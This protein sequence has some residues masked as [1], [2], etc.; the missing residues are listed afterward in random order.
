M[1]LINLIDKSHI[2]YLEELYSWY[3]DTFE[4]LYNSLD[5]ITICP[6]KEDYTININA[7]V[8]QRLKEKWILLMAYNNMEEIVKLIK[9]LE[10]KIYINTFREQEILNKNLLKKAVWQKTTDEPEI[11]LDKFLQK[12]IIWKQFPE[13]VANHILLEEN[14]SILRKDFSRLEFPLIIKPVWWTASFGVKKVHDMKELVASIKDINESMNKLWEYW[15]HKKNIVIE[16]FIEWQLYAITYFVDEEQN[17]HL[18]RPILQWD[19][20]LGKDPMLM[21]GKLSEEIESHIDKKVLE[22]FVSKTVR[23]WGIRNTFVCHQFKK[24]PQWKL[25]TIELNWRIWWFNI[26]M[27][28]YS[29]GINLLK[30]AFLWADYK[31][32]EKII[33]SSAA[34]RIYADEE[35]IFNGYKQV[36]LETIKKLQSLKRD[37]FNTTTWIKVWPPQLW[38]YYYWIVL[39]KNHDQETFNRDFNYVNENYFN[40]LDK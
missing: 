35:I 11:F 26:E 22:E 8:V 24:T 16:E 12:N 6:Y 9:W 23:W 17:I 28:K 37:I 40:L 15:L 36:I 39:L 30:F 20:A 18:T 32:S 33:H 38:Y 31:F 21:Y 19:K 3:I 7:E 29:Y 14:E 13:T 2:N 10:W 5:V 27:Y 4:D 1:Y 34:F 25:K